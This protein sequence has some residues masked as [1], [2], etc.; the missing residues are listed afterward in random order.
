MKPSLQLASVAILTLV[1][2]NSWTRCWAQELETPQAQIGW[3][4]LIGKELRL[5]KLPPE[6]APALPSWVA[7]GQR[8]GSPGSMLSSSDSESALAERIKLTLEQAI[9][10]VN[11]YLPQDLEGDF[12]LWIFQDIPYAAKTL[13][14]QLILSADVLNSRNW[15]RLPFVLAHEIH[16]LALMR[17]GFLTAHPSARAS[18]LAGLLTE[19]IA[20]WLSYASGLFPELDQILQ[21]PQQLRASF[22]QIRQAL[23]RAEDHAPARLDDLYG[24]NKW[25]YYVGCWMIQQ[26]E[27]RFGREAWLALLSKSP[28]EANEELVQLYLGTNPPAEYR[29]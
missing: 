28:E 7:H 27:E 10:I 24:Q 4:V 2:L 12:K 26:I 18:I 14:P 17:T 19:G 25:G 15:D 21:E 13:N 29:F 5:V 22:H 20:T 11:D 3:K 1:L 16:H 9:Q 23:D 8:S 6:T